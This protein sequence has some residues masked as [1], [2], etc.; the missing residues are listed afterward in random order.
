MLLT[1]T[2]AAERGIEIGPLF[3]RY[4]QM[5]FFAGFLAGFYLMRRYFSKEGVSQEVLDNLLI[6]TVVATIIGARLGHVFFYDWAYYKQHVTEIFM[7]WKGGLASHGAAVVI[8]LVLYYFTK[9]QLK[10]SGKSFL[11]LMDRVVIT[12]ALA[13]AFIRLGNF[14]N[15][16]IYGEPANQ[17][18]ET[19]FL[20]PVLDY[21]ETYFS[22][23]VESLQFESTGEVL[24]TDSL[25][26]PQYDLIITPKG[27]TEIG[28]LQS[29]VEVHLIPLFN[30]QKKDNRHLYIPEDA[31]LQPSNNGK[32]HLTV[33][34]IPRLP[35]Q[36]AESL[37]YLVIFGFLFFLGER[38][39]LQYEG[40]IFGLFLVT[41]FG[42]RILIEFFKANQKAFEAGMSLNMGQWL[43]I[44]LVVIGLILFVQSFLSRSKS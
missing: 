44:P 6:Y 42:F 28:A 11:W 23:A 18:F 20:R 43:S 2:W 15:S 16:E 37:A 33:Y 34:G 31:Y 35:S 22:N 17:Q 7:P 41:V 19:V 30:L 10:S 1:L 24:E 38:K 36:L 40:R 8:P 32:F 4:Y 12:V 26:L 3:L 13:G 5:L 27:K 25:S 29:I 9:T 39:Q 21:S 14:T